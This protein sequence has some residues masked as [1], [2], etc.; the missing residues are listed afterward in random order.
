[1]FFFNAAHCLVK[2]SELQLYDRSAV[3]R[4]EFAMTQNANIAK[5]LSKFCPMKTCAAGNCASL[6]LSRSLK[7]GGWNDTWLQFPAISVAKLQ[8]LRKL[9]QSTHRD[10]IHARTQSNSNWVI[11]SETQKF[12]RWQNPSQI[13]IIAF[14]PSIFTHWCPNGGGTFPVLYSLYHRKIKLF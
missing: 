6:P 2:Y 9:W 12:G 1:M 3:C 7:R 8:S 14:I 13:L 4:L 10:I 11:A 5:L